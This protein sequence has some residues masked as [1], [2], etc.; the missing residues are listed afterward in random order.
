MLQNVWFY[1]NISS[2]FRN[3]INM[4]IVRFF[5]CYIS[6]IGELEAL[7]SF[8]NSLVLFFCYKILFLLQFSSICI[9]CVVLPRH[10]TIGIIPLVPFFFWENIPL[11]LITGSYVSVTFISN[12]Y[13]KVWTLYNYMKFHVYHKRKYAFKNYENAHIIYI[14]F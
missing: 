1:L 8:K 6:L 2:L 11:V 5:M 10:K 9:F 14:H 3:V 7:S 4:K 13:S 12:P